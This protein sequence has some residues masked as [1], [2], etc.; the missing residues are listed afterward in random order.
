M[1]EKKR[2][3]LNVLLIVLSAGIVAACICGIIA[4]SIFMPSGKA[5]VAFSSVKNGRY[6]AT[7]NTEALFGSSDVAIVIE[8]RSLQELDGDGALAI[9]FNNRT[10][11]VTV[12]EE[13]A[14]VI[15]DDRDVRSLTDYTKFLLKVYHNDE[16]INLVCETTTSDDGSNIRNALKVY[17]ENDETTS[18]V[19]KWER[20]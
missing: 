16:V 12:G 5:W 15:V 13:K 18:V 19:F 8:E 6:V 2:I 11:A 17:S 20:A 1:A 3:V 14:K 9:V 10:V 4:M 7:D